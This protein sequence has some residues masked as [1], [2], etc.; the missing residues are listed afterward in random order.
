ML[1]NQ[2]M[3]NLKSAPV[4]VIHPS[5]LHELFIQEI[6]VRGVREVESWLVQPL[7]AHRCRKLP[8]STFKITSR[9]TVT[10]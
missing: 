10:V 3:G 1:E 7:I 6:Q 5:Q 8:L 9:Q 4:F 2:C